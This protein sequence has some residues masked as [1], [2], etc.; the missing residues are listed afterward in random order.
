M[1]FY[2]AFVKVASLSSIFHGF[3]E[4]RSFERLADRIRSIIQSAT[5]FF[6]CQP[7]LCGHAVLTFPTNFPSL[8]TGCEAFRLEDSSVGKEMLQNL[9]F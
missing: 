7:A 9:A 1:E 5:I 8:D 6:L 4:A 3:G 2:E